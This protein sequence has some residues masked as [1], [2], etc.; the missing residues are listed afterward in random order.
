MPE[1]G[2]R[3]RRFVRTSPPFGEGGGCFD[4][5]QWC[6]QRHQPHLV[7]LEQ[8]C[9]RWRDGLAEQPDQRARQCAVEGGVPDGFE[10]A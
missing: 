6:D 3:V 2:E 8:G 1:L 4:R 9:D 7:H 10:P 5:V